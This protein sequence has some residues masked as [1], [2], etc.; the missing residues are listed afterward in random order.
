[1]TPLTIASG[2]DH[3]ITVLD[4]RQDHRWALPSGPTAGFPREVFYHHS[5]DRRVA[6]GPNADKLAIMRAMADSD[7]FGLPYN[8]L[9]WPDLT[10]FY[11][12]DV[13]RAWPHTFGHNGAVA[14]AAQGDYDV[15]DVPPDLADTMGRLTW[16]LATMWGQWLRERFHSD[17][18]A[19]ACPGRYLK[20]A[21]VNADSYSG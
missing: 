16:A 17:V 6:A 2:S 21:L 4:V 14:I 12:N 18:F 7:K 20:P 3:A 5:D 10:I 13:D 9:I 8:F 15:F 11:V 19:T 1:M